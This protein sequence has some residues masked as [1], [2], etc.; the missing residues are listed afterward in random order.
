[1]V[2]DQIRDKLPYRFE[3]MGEQSVKNITRPV[4]AYAINTAAVVSSSSV[5]APVEPVLKEVG[6]P[7]PI[8]PRLS[9]VVLPFANL[10]DDPKQDYFADGITDDLTTDLS[11]ISE[12]FVIARNTAFT[13]KGKAVDVKE[14]GREL[15]VLYVLEG[16]V[17]RTGEQVRVNVQL[18]DTER[19]A[20]VWA[21]RFDADRADLAEA[22]DEITGRLARMLNLELLADVSRRI[23]LDSG[24]DPD[25]RDFVMQG[26]SWYYRPYST[27]SRREAQRAFER[28]LEIHPASVDARIGVAAVL[29]ANLAD[30]WSSAREQ[31]EARTEQLLLEAFER[32][33]NCSMTHFAMGILRRVQNRFAEALIEFE[34]AIALDR[35][36]A[37]AHLQLGNTLLFM[38]Q[39][40]AGVPH[41]EKAIRLNPY[42]PNA[43]TFYLVLGLCRVFL[44]QVDKAIE[45]LRRARASNPR[46]PVVHFYLAGVF[47]L[48]GDFD[49]ARSVLGDALKLKPEVNSI[50]QLRAYRPW[51]TNPPF[52]ALLE[53]TINLGLRR[54]GFPDK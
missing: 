46:L 43:A 37:R 38:G 4:R 31:D 20:H 13:F 35:N 9:V 39:P 54:A 30:G 41:I 26:W 16:S 53:Q 8:L 17:R 32:D 24:A 50:E 2:R 6:K 48:M 22:Q 36:N 27:A 29:A 33:Q 7:G 5:V 1:V 18:I 25:A 28:A 51:I 40:E 23:D 10:S 11:R 47:G 3:D 44:G 49:E 45:L 21:D 12:S 14:I 19:G 52:W 34:A 42:D 15:G